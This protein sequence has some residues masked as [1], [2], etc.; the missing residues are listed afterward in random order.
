VMFKWVLASGLN[1]KS[2]NNYCDPIEN[3]HRI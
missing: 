1:K 2:F 3:S